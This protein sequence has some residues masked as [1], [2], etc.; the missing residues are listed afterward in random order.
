VLPVALQNDAY[1]YYGL[2]NAKP[3]DME[4]RSSAQPGT[5]TSGAQTTTLTAADEKTAT[6][7]V[8]RSGNLGTQLGNM[9][10]SLESDGV[11][12]KSSDVADVGKH[13][14]E[15]PNNI[16]PGY[17]WTSRTKVTQPNRE[18]DL[19]LTSKVVGFDELKTKSGK[20]KAL[21][22]TSSGSGTILKQKTRM[23]SKSWFVKDVG[24]VV[25]EMITIPGKG[26]SQTVTI[27]AAGY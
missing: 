27:R 18:I 15:F 6:F 11:Y 20:V 5:V 24:N 7:R 2:S 22:V 17:V 10:V 19:T 14:L 21:L 8:E 9:E 23:E 3:L 13:D 25:S 4:V 26:E 16:T 12:V 1:R